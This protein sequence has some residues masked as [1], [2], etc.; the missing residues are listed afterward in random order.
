M[1]NWLIRLIWGT[2]LV[3]GMLQ[4]GTFADEPD[5]AQAAK[6]A[7][8]V[9]TL[10]R[11]EGFDI[12]ARPDIKEAVLRHLGTI[13]K[14][15]QY[16]I[17]ARRFELKETSDELVALMLDDPVSTLG[18]EA[19]K[20]LLKF[21][22][23]PRL[24]KL[25]NG[26]DADAAA[27]CVTALG[28][29]GDNGSFEFMARLP[30]DERRPVKVRVAAAQ[31]LARSRKGEERLMELVVTK[32][33]PADLSFTVANALFASPDE[34]TRAWAAKHLTLPAGANSTT[35]PPVAELVKQQGDA[36]Q[37]KTVFNNAGTCAKC[38][39]VRGQGKEVGPDLSEIGS[40]LSKEALFV[41]ILD[42]NAGISHNYETYAAVLDDGNVVSGILVSQTDDTVV[43]KTAEA[44]IRK[45]DRSEIDTLQKQPVSLMPSDLQKNLTA[46][47]LVD[48]VEYLTALKKNTK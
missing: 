46:Q 4:C 28:L 25:M 26:E 13:K 47:N 36:E 10:S 15:E 35:L 20:L 2:F 29:T 23:R 38:H 8:I 30:A 16:L 7:R 11:L 43:L 42:P 39:V 48:V 44:I 45:L 1:R 34:K 37:G 27:K 33:L 14:T 22:E 24:T 6:D 19:A 12:S 17:L 9:E 18:V 3:P 41:S 31:A 21:G 5:P 40:K 32:R